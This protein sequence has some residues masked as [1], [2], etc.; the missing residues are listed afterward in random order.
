M[1]ASDLNHKNYEAYLNQ[2][3]ASG[4]AGIKAFKA[5]ASTWE[6]TAWG[7]AFGELHDELQDTH[8]KVKELIH[9]LGYRVSGWR[10]LVAGFANLVGLVNPVNVTRDPEGTMAQ[11]QLDYL[12]GAVRAQQM[13]WETLLALADIDERLD[14]G[15]CR[16][17]IARCESQRERVLTASRQTVASRFTLPAGQP[18]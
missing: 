2:H 12:A 5:A 18:G 16:A 14:K 4:D 15:M 9:D 11:F 10:N 3:L 6:G 13:M 8:A 17:M 7:A 1:Q